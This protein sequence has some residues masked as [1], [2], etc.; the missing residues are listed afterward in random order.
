MYRSGEKTLSTP[1]AARQIA[2]RAIQ[3]AAKEPNGSLWSLITARFFTAFMFDREPLR[4]RRPDRP[5]R[6]SVVSTRRSLIALVEMPVAR[7]DAKVVVPA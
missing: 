2:F 7:P 4:H 3:S 5:R 6:A 1:A